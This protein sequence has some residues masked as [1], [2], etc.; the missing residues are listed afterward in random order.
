MTAVSTPSLEEIRRAGLEALH[1][2]LG[3]AGMLRFL[4][5]FSQGSGDYTKDRHQ[6]L[7]DPSVAG[8]VEAYERHRAAEQH[9]RS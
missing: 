5:Y 7:G 3:P 2:E 8:I 9:A 6:L 1:R 4:L